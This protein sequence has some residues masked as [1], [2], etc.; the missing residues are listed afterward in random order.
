MHGGRHQESIACAVFRGSLQ[1]L[2]DCKS[3]YSL[4]FVCGLGRCLAAAPPP[5]TTHARRRRGH[6]WTTLDADEQDEL[7]VKL[8]F[9]IGLELLLGP[10]LAAEAREATAS[11]PR[12]PPLLQAERPLLRSAATIRARAS[13]LGVGA[14]ARGRWLTR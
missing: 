10:A 12:S 5:M 4:I 13:A 1:I 6:P 3:Y 9:G 2:L 11:R 8:R 14:G 7:A